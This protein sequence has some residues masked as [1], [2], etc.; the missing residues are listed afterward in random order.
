M[1]LIEHG[2]AGVLVALAAATLWTG[3][4]SGFVLSL[5]LVPDVIRWTIRRMQG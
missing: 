3:A 1:G 4:V 5:A 2:A